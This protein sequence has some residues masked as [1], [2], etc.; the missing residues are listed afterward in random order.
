MG[1]NQFCFECWMRWEGFNQGTNSPIISTTNTGGGN[2]FELRIVGNSLRLFLASI[3]TFSLYTLNTIEA[4]PNWTH[5][6]VT[7]AAGDIFRVFV[8]GTQVG[9]TLGPYASYSL[10]NP[11]MQIGADTSSNY[12]R[13]FLDEIR[14]TNFNPRYTANFTPPTEP[15]PDC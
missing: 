3:G 8:N 10:T 7:R 12:F 13:G 14:L 2:Y 9:T 1:Q 4:A 11:T 15:F 5:V 6:A